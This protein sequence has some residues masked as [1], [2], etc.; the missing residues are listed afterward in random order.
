MRQI[1]RTLVVVALV[2][3]AIIAATRWPRINVVETG[4]TPEY[5]ELREREFA[6]PEAV[7]GRAAKAAV[8]ALPGWTFVGAGQGP[9]GTSIQALA[10]NPA[11]V[12]TEMT[13]TIR[14]QSGKT[15][16]RVRARSTFGPWDFG[17]G[18]RH[19]EAFLAELDRQIASPPPR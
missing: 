2:A 10:T 9:G 5:P 17:Q 4:R 11:P 12:K 15:M 19:I 18:A 6:N 14:R 8:A 13:V 7:V 16:V 1:V 3:A